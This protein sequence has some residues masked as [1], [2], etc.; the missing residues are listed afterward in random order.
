MIFSKCYIFLPF[1]QTR[2]SLV[3]DNPRWNFQ[4]LSGETQNV[5]LL[6]QCS[7][8]GEIDVGGVVVVDA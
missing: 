5:T 1:S 3:N 2:L 6:F 7:K 8:S 4:E